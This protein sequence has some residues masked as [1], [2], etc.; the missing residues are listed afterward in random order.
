M[1]RCHPETSAC[2]DDNPPVLF[3]H[4]ENPAATVTD[5]FLTSSIIS[6]E[7][8]ICGS[9]DSAVRCKRKY[10]STRSDKWSKLVKKLRLEGIEIFFFLS[11][12][13]FIQIYKLLLL[14]QFLITDL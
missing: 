3:N 11:S 6:L 10:N 8:D 1:Q 5:A 7:R 12:E 4:G 9:N 2:T 14:G 13:D